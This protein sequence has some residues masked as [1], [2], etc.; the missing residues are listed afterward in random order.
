MF[1]FADRKGPPLPTGMPKGAFSGKKSDTPAKGAAP[2]GT[3]SKA[4]AAHPDKSAEKSSSLKMPAPSAKTEGQP[5]QNKA[6]T[7]R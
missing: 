5:A 2:K 4:D 1:Y 6:D 7:S 3:P